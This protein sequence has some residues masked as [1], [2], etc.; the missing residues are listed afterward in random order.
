MNKTDY[1]NKINDLLNDSTTYKIIHKDPTNTYQNTANNLITSWVK[2][3]NL[4]KNAATKLKTHN[5]LPP[6]IYGLPKLHKINHPLRPIVSCIQ[7]PFYNIAKYLTDILKNIV[8]KTETYTKDSW[9]F[10][11]FINQITIPDNYTLISL[12]VISLYTNTPIDLAI[13]IITN[14]WTDIQQHT[15]LNLQQF[16]HAVKLTL[17]STYFQYNEKFY[18]QIYGCAMG[19]PISSVIAQ[20]VL[21]HLEET[22]LP[23]ITYPIPFFKRYVDDCIT[24][25]P[26]NHTEDILYK[27]NTF[28][29]K[30]QFTI[31]KSQNNTINFL[32]LTL[33]VKNKE[34]LTEWY[35]KPTWSGRY[36]NYN[37]AQPYSHKINVANGIADRAIALSSPQFRPQAIQKAK[38]CLKLNNFP[39]PSITNIFKKR[40]YKF[41][42]LNSANLNSTKTKTRYIPI[43]YTPTLSENISKILKK[44]EFTSAHTNHHNLKH[45]YTKLKSKTP[46]LDNTHI[47]YKISCNNCP[48]TYIG[49]TKQHLKDRLYQHEHYKTNK[50]AVT[51][52]NEQTGHKFNFTDPKILAKETRLKPRLILETINIKKEKHAINDQ[53]DSTNLS[54]IYNTIL[55]NK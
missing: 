10:K 43:P 23:T 34:I 3:G 28:N 9:T 11:T 30:L 24:A 7:S 33:T 52:H 26:N 21:E 40:T 41:Y 4:N 27:F 22:I 53:L 54:D 6:K 42:N 25:V 8:N 45:L 14:K 47:V 1:N 19:N 18:Q 51:K 38:E 31:E 17:N 55:N 35:T 48:A 37:S 46:T 44:H 16:T 49:Q 29:Q 12:D 20:L 2:N 50:T 13:E 32:D 5:A 36:I 39:H 15:T